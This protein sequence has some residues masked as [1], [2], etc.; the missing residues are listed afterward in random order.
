MTMPCWSNLAFARGGVA[1][2]SPE[3]ELQAEQR[4]ARGLSDDWR[5]WQVGDQNDHYANELLIRVMMT[6]NEL[7]LYKMCEPA[8]NGTN[9]GLNDI[10]TLPRFKSSIKNALHAAY[11]SQIGGFISVGYFGKRSTIHMVRTG[12]QKCT[13]VC[14][15]HVSKNKV[16]F[17]FVTL[18]LKNNQVLWVLR[19]TY[20]ILWKQNAWKCTIAKK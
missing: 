7:C 17:F 16:H 6:S 1:V 14:W 18:Q 15:V 3:G 9:H 19:P 5:D 12:V 11:W 2:Q 13:R 4:R 10:G 8:K 20:F